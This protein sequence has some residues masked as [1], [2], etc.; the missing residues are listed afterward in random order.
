MKKED[1]NTLMRQFPAPE[2]K[3]KFPLA[4]KKQKR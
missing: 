4:N 3:S 2:N 1:R